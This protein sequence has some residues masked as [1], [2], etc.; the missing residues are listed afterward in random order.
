LWNYHVT[1]LMV[2]NNYLYNYTSY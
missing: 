1:T 2:H